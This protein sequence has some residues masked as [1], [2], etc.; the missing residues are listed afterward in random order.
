MER[1]HN[2]ERNQTAQHGICYLGTKL[3]S[4]Q[5]RPQYVTLLA[6]VLNVC[7]LC[8]QRKLVLRHPIPAVACRVITHNHL[9]HRQQPQSC[10]HH[11]WAG[12]GVCSLPA[13]AAV[14]LAKGSIAVGCYCVI[15][16]PF[17][18][19]FTFSTSDCAPQWVFI[20]FSTFELTSSAK[21][22]L[23]TRYVP[24]ARLPAC[25]LL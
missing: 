21:V 25:R 22:S 16:R 3:P 12:Y 8:S 1:C 18:H 5:S 17:T 4:D 19:P 20:L 11:G 10:N 2:Q 7:H 23:A 9:V 24:D 6:G 14:L 15:V 13:K